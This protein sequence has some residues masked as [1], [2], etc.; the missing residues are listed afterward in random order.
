M[1]EVSLAWLLSKVT[2]PVVGMTKPGHIDGAVKAVELELSE[3]EVRYLEE[4]YQSHK[5]VGVM[6]DNH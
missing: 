6:A 4:L 1:T 5:L 3:E 2:S